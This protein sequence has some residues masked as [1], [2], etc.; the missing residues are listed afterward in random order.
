[1]QELEDLQ[2]VQK[3]CSMDEAIIYPDVIRAE[4][5]A[6]GDVLLTLGDKQTQKSKRFLL[7]KETVE[8]LGQVLLQE[9]GTTL[10]FLLN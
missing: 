10:N 6:N 3:L 5:Y 2:Q 7:G 1:M 4:R 8:K 9:P